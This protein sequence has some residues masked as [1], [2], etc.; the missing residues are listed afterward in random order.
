MSSTLP[1]S[2]PRSV[3]VDAASSIV[4]WTALLPSMAASWSPCCTPLLPPLPSGTTLE[5][6]HPISCSLNSTGGG[7]KG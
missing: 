5:T 3:M 7:G 6:Q 2:F 4:A 1:P